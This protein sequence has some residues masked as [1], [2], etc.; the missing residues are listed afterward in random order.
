MI[1]AALLLFLVGTA[2]LVRA[3]GNAIATGASSP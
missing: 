1:A 3:R 2:D